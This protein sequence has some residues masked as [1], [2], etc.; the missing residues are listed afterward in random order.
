[1]ER[2]RP[3]AQYRIVGLTGECQPEKVHEAAC[4]PAVHDFHAK[5]NFNGT[6]RLV[7]DDRRCTH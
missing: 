3:Q 5:K 1:V 4:M 6:I 7:S 2:L